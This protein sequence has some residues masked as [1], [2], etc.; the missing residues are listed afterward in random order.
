[1]C[2][3]T[4]ILLVSLLIRLADVAYA[5]DALTTKELLGRNIYRNGSDGSLAEITATLAAVE[6][7]VSATAFACASCHGLEG[8]GKQEG[9][10]NVPPISS[11][12]LFS[13]SFST[14]LPKKS[15]DEN[16]LV[17]AVTKGISSQNTPLSAAM[18]RYGL[19]DHQAQA[20]VAYLKQLGSANDVDVGITDTEVQL[21]AVLPLTGSQAATGKLLKATLDA[22]VANLNS[23]GLVYGRKITLTTLD[24]G[25][26]KAEILASTQRLITETKPFAL[27]SG[28]FPEVTA[29][30]YQLLQNEKIPVIAPLTFVP[31]EGSNQSPSF[32][33]FLPSYADQSRALVDYWLTQLPRNRR[34]TRQKLALVYSERA[35][36]LTTV[37]AIREQVQRNALRAPI[38][39]VLSQIDSKQAVSQLTK[40]KTAKPDAIFF[41]GNTQE[42]KDYKLLIAQSNQRPILLGLLAMLGADI[43]S[44]P[45][46]AVS[47]MLLATPFNLNTPAMRQFAILLNQHSLS[48][49]SPGLQRIAC[50]AVNFVAEGLKRSGKRLSRNKF[51]HAL[52]E[53]KIYPVDIMPPLQFKPNNRKGVRGAYIL[54]V[55]TKTGSLSPPSAWIAPSDEVSIQ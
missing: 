19:S 4:L 15:Y 11:Q 33:Y 21:G 25:S 42:L 12:H 37:R 5:D 22:C 46:L 36:D 47:K 6:D 9:G 48:L 39:I 30:I 26:T 27:I 53:F 41:L 54:T 1:M 31:N 18:P 29:D 7:S 20:L 51:I 44:I 3:K 24:S 55:D 38:E 23:Q 34:S 28:Y 52:G 14:S 16:T 43:M 45:E 13:N 17:L 40:L 50:S 2:F 10:L 32:F 8:E 49:Q 35:T